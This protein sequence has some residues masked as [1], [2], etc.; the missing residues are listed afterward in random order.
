MNPER[1]RQ[2]QALYQAAVELEPRPRE[3]FLNQV[4][5]ND[6]SLR[7]ELDSLLGLNQAAGHFLE[8]PAME[9]AARNLARDEANGLSR[10]MIGRSL[11]HYQIGEPIGRGGMGIVYLAYDTHLRRE[12]A[13]K[14]L[15][16]EVMV[17]PERK[18]RFV[19]EARAASALNH[20]NIV[21]IYDISNADGVDFIAMELVRGKTL[22]RMIGDSRLPVGVTM[23]LAVQIV[24]AV[25]RTHKA[26]IIHRDLK[27]ANIMVTD[28]GLVKV[29]DFGLAKLSHLETGT[30]DISTQTIK[31]RTEAGSVAGTPAYMSPEQALGRQV[32]ARTDIFSIGVV[33]FQCLTGRL[34]FEHKSDSPFP[35]N[36]LWKQP[37]PLRSLVPEAPKLLERIVQ[38][39]LEKDP[40]ERFE[41]ADVLAEELNRAL[42]YKHGKRQWALK[43][44]ALVAIG[45]ALSMGIR[46]CVIPPGPASNTQSTVNLEQVITWESDDTDSRIS[47]DQKFLSFI[48]NRSGRNEIWLKNMVG[49]E[50][51]SI[52]SHP[53]TILSH[54]WSPGGTEIAYL[55]HDQSRVLLQTAPALMG[56]APGVTPEVD[57]SCNRI[58]RWIGQHIYMEGGESL[59]QYDLKTQALRSMILSRPPELKYMRHFDVRRDELR[60][61]FTAYDRGKESLWTADLDG[62]NPLRLT[63]GDAAD[64]HPLWV[65]AHGPDVIYESSRGGQLNIFTV[66]T[67]GGSPRQITSGAEETPEDIS[68][69][70]SILTFKVTKDDAH[71]WSL[72]P[73]TR[74]QHQLTNDS[75]SDLWPTCANSAGPVAFQRKPPRG[76]AG[77]TFLEAQILIGDL[78]ASGISAPIKL[79]RDGYSARLSPDGRWLAYL[80]WT[81]TNNQFSELWVI[82]PNGQ[83]PHRVTVHCPTLGVTMFPI[84]FLFANFAWSANSQYLYFIDEAISGTSRV[85]RYNLGSPGSESETVLSAAANQRIGELRVAKDG[86]RISYVVRGGQD[87]GSVE[88]HVHDMDTGEN[89]TVY[90]AQHIPKNFVLFSRGWLASG[91]SMIVLPAVINADGTQSI[92]IT[93]VGASG[94]SR[95]LK[96]VDGAFGA[97]AKL[98]PLSQTLY[99]T[100]AKQNIHNLW[101]FSIANGEFHQLTE[102]TWPSVSFSGIEILS[103][104]RILY[105]RLDRHGDISICRFE[106]HN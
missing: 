36:W 30:S 91:Q 2:I 48:S 25:T 8:V 66:S 28:E 55:V 54:A 71:L 95:L 58:I 93:K 40:A 24:D 51:R 79:V 13:V 26:G 68:E 87:P 101:S 32:D 11:A 16:P 49:G 17:D 60:I 1:W 43:I 20:P 99:L 42:Q 31:P 75:L 47:P 29:M 90:S 105:S 52:R 33:M 27:P 65:Q 98:D 97:T 35:L 102:N 38:R 19:E 67:Q 53:G 86:S 63:T 70:G 92:E 45:I 96:R 61:V 41:S 10:T 82:E 72:D 88:V 59:F 57:A 80:K 85:R 106:S 23:Q 18:R 81:T 103:D 7:R 21:T 6:E 74:A 39:C 100:M 64:R 62:K 14:T 44:A 83:G 69:D 94:G 5:G 73:K 9:I 77:Y 15:R 89:R 3:V 34:P 22:A 78:S 50:A 37:L 4:C 56:G 76:Q 12:V 104:G 46:I 84:D